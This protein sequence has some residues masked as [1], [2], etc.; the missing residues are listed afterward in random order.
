MVPI[1]MILG[2]ILAGEAIA[3]V[4]YENL[5]RR[6]GLWQ[7]KSSLIP[8]TGD[9]IWMPEGSTNPVVIRFENGIKV[10]KNT[11]TQAFQS[12]QPENSFATQP[13]IPQSGNMLGQVLVSKPASRVGPLLKAVNRTGTSAYLVSDTRPVQIDLQ[14][15]APVGQLVSYQVVT[16]PKLGSLSVSQN[17]SLIYTPFQGKRGEDSFGFLASDSSGRSSGGLISL[18]VGVKP[19]SRDT[20][21]Y[22]VL[23]SSLSMAATTG[24]LYALKNNELRQSLTQFYGSKEAYEKKVK[25]ISSQSERTFAFL[26]IQFPYAGLISDLIGGALTAPAPDQECVVIVFQ[27]EAHPDY[28]N[29][30][31]LFTRQDA[32]GWARPSMVMNIPGTIWAARAVDYNA[33]P[34]DITHLRNCLSGRYFRRYCGIVMALY[35]PEFPAFSRLVDAVFRGTGPFTSNG[36]NLREFATG[37]DPKLR[38][39][40][41]LPHAAGSRYYFDRLRI[42][43]MEAGLAIPNVTSSFA[44]EDSDSSEGTSGKQKNSWSSRQ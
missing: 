21:I 28:H 34:A 18:M 26:S 11:T 14:A 22:I 36:H 10:E 19:V 40:A 5:E 4:K 16:Q 44:E 17:G 37:K 12:K 2:L 25:V 27:D 43:A 24:D 38:L 41:N 3:A 30:Y 35:S 13:P 1:I 23:D 42:A 9:A 8:F 32:D 20:S 39:V 15:E 7:I 6:D 29:P 31:G 33:L